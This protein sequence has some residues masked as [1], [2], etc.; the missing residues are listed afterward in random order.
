MANSKQSPS[1][2]L[3]GY[4]ITDFKA[5]SANGNLNTFRTDG[6]YCFGSIHNSENI[7]NGNSGNLQV[8]TG[9]EGN[10]R[11]CKQIFHEHYTGQVFSRWQLDASNNNWSPW[12]KITQS[13]SV[14]KGTINNGATLPLPSG[15]SESQ[16]HWIVSINDDVSLERIDNTNTG[17]TKTECYVDNHR[18][19]VVRVFSKT[20][21]NTDPVTRRKFDN[22]RANYLVIGVK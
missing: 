6:V 14:I 13:I 5:Q 4:G 8:I 10:E 17:Y 20:G 12:L 16:C 15:Y 9:G 3:A 11:W 22:S 18:R 19:V 21:L 1:H 7:P 2:T